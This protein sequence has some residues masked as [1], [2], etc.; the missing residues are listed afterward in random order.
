MHEL[1]HFLEN[2]MLYLRRFLTAVLVCMLQMGAAYAAPSAT[3]ILMRAEDLLWGKSTL[4]GEV[5]MTITNPSWSR[6]LRFNIWMERP[7]KSFVRISAPAKDAGTASLRI[8]P[9][10]WSYLPEIERTIKIPPSLMLQPWLGS[11]FSN[12]DI[13]KDSSLI[14]DYTHRQLP[15]TQVDG[16]RAYRIECL[17]KA[18]AAV[19]WG[20]I[21]YTVRSSDFMP[22]KIEYFNERG[23]VNRMLTYSDMRTMGG[24]T[25]PTRWEMVS[26]IKPGKKTTITVKSATYEKPVDPSIFS[27][28]NL[29][30]R[31]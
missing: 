22:L 24:H 15:D 10:M 28:R 31:G 11:D 14:D 4:N 1:C 29:K 18:E 7:G 2:Q 9:E 3:D 21:I 19:V 23:E 20:K 26:L 6:T 25:I 16:Q 12:D 27:Q 8:G 30:Q 13:V 17:P 5:E